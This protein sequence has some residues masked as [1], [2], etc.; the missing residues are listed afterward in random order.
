[1]SGK[2]TADSRVAVDSVF[3]WF[4]GGRMTG[5]RRGR[6]GFN[7][8]NSAYSGRIYTV[9]S[10]TG[11]VFNYR[12]WL[13]VMGNGNRRTG[14]SDT[15]DFSSDFGAI[16]FI[17][18]FATGNAIPSGSIT[19]PVTGLV[20][21]PL[22]FGIA[23]A[24]K[25]E[26]VAH[27]EWDLADGKGYQ[28]GKDTVTGRWL[29]PGSYGIQARLTDIDSNVAV[30]T[31]T[32]NVTNQAAVV[33]GIR[34]TVITVG[35]VVNFSLTVHDTDGVAKVLWDFGDGK[36]DSTF[37]GETHSVSHRYP[38]FDSL[39]IGYPATSDSILKANGRDY[40]LTVTVVD[41]LG[42]QTVQTAKIHVFDDI[43]VVIVHDTVGA[44]DE[45]VTL[46]ASTNDRGT[47]TKV[48][49]S[50][51]GSTFATG[52][53]DTTIKLPST[54]TLNYPVLV[55]VTDEDGN[56]SKVD[57]AKV[58]V[59]EMITDARDGQRYQIVTIGTQTWMAQNLNY[60]V[61]S[62]WW[63]N[64]SAD[65]GAKY[66]RLYT[67]GSAMSLPDSCNNVSCSNSINA[68]HQGICPS[69]W[70]IPSTS[71]ISTLTSYISYKFNS[72]DSISGYLLRTSDGWAWNG[73]TYNGSDTCGLS[74]KP[75]GQYDRLMS[76]SFTDVGSS[77]QMW[78]INERPNVDVAWIFYIYAYSKGSQ[79]G[80][81]AKSG[82][83]SSVRCIKN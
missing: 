81:A 33:A 51:N 71:E 52:G 67:W 64:N 29:L 27:L 41:R 83:L 60:M 53:K 20:N 6:L 75:S 25:D 78:T 82:F 77:F 17:P 39:K 10:L 65:S 36:K 7:K 31:K 72:P 32:V 11:D 48:E 24:R 34:D 58:I 74:I 49:W 68:Q 66:G 69:G 28:A 56:V 62:S 42:N 80:W 54:T 8:A 70:H 43:P 22:A 3:A 9:K 1:M 50:V 16:D 13:N 44:P 40:P 15:T 21:T 59:G 61:D 47:I 73:K 14:I 26:Q 57:S 30:L 23:L 18:L 35:D 38:T 55:R 37:T 5:M 45:A 79:I 46:H 76:H 4:D 19:G 63:Y 2:V 12:V